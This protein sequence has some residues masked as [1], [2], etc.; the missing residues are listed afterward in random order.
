MNTNTANIYITATDKTKS[1][2]A[3]LNAGLGSVI[4]KLAG[5]AAAAGGIA[6]I[7]TSLQKFADLN[8]FSNF[9]IGTDKALLYIDTLKLAG[10]E[11]GEV[12]KTFEE[13]SIK[14]SE[15]VT[16]QDTANLFKQLGVD[17][18]SLK[19][20]KIEVI[21]DK[22]RDSLSKTEDKAKSLELAKKILG[23][24]A[25]K[26]LDSSQDEEIQAVEARLK[27]MTAE[28]KATSYGADELY[29]NFD[30]IKI[31]VQNELA[32]SFVSVLVPV[33]AF[34][35]TIINSQTELKKVKT[36]SDILADAESWSTLIEIGFR[37]GDIVYN[38][39]NRGLQI[40]DGSLNF[41]IGTLKG[42]ISLVDLVG[43]S[44]YYG[45]TEAF[46]GAQ[47]T[48]TDLFEAVA[49]AAKGN[50]EDAGKALDSAFTGGKGMQKYVDEVT[51]PLN[52]INAAATQAR[53]GI[54]K[55]FNLYWDPTTMD[56]FKTYQTNF[57]KQAKKTADAINET[58]DAMSG[59]TN[60]KGVTPAGANPLDLLNSKLKDIE[61]F[62]QKSKYYT[63][64]QV[65]YNELAYNDEL[66]SIEEYY[67]EKNRLAEKD[68]LDNKKYIEDQI[69]VNQLF[70]PK[71][72][73]ERIQ[74]DEKIAELKFK[75]IK[76][77][78]DYR[79][80]VSQTN[81]KELKERLDLKNQQ[82]SADIEILSIQEEVF[83]FQS[84]MSGSNYFTTN[85][86]IVSLRKQ[87][88]ELMKE[89]IALQESKVNKTPKE[90]LELEKAKL[91]LMKFK[92]EVD[93]IA[94]EINKSLDSAFGTFFS[95]TL[96]GTKSIKDA[97][98]DMVGSIDSMIM[99]FI[100]KSLGEQL[101]GSLFPKTSS[102]GGFGGMISDFFSGGSK[103]GGGG[104][105]LSGIGDFISGFFATGGYAQSGS[106]YVVGEKGPE[107]FFPN[108]SGYV[109]SNKDSANIAGGSSQPI[110]VNVYAQDTRGFESMLSTGQMQ[111]KI[112]QQ[113]MA[114]RRNM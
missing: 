106:A 39:W 78:E 40:V 62:S 24:N 77:E 6:L 88:I 23:K 97:F 3:S 54:E 94:T 86:E 30:R 19:N 108:Q 84:K 114:G 1:A 10:M 60:R 18:K 26:I 53:D 109:A 49:L 2:F 65:K 103:G 81:S 33:N 13:L 91:S 28:I 16:N 72:Q 52:A 105:M 101:I 58:N 35:D 66:K 61:L 111:A 89:D 67:A 43:K 46:K 34:L 90:R 75:A 76:N 37:F 73:K 68:Y 71:D 80:S 42:V 100:A 83:A 25:I 14:V 69:K 110:I 47:A 21:F 98:K 51:K 5:L 12:K 15:G 29:K 92:D 95:D 64:L 107:L 32:T 41:I 74:T 9:D 31:L 8:D 20:E 38:V 87:S 102:S 82:L 56:K 112:N 44:I 22:I 59:K 113:V 70:N 57:A 11:I 85:K 93:P 104:G 4:T 79:L 45:I 63:D 50:F 27:S 96:N 55:P 7:N 48:A 36:A 99:N 17:A